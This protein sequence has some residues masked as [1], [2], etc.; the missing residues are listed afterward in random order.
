MAT[1]QVR[2]W[3]LEARLAPAPPPG[4]GAVKA[5]VIAKGKAAAEGKAA[6]K[7]KTAAAGKAAAKGEAA[8]KGKAAAEGKATGA[9]PKHKAA[10]KAKAAVKAAAKGKAKAAEGGVPIKPES[11]TTDRGTISVIV[12]KTTGRAYISCCSGGERQQWIQISQSDADNLGMTP[13]EAIT[14]IF[15]RVESEGLDMQGAKDAKA[16]LMERMAPSTE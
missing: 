14:H 4:K 12:D 9:A 8:A 16:N 3:N 15:G 6:A 1:T 2:A 7:G 10:G 5:A 13:L 11:I